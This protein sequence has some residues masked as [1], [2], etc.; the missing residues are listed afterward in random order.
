MKRIFTFIIFSSLVF[1]GSYEI[2]AQ[3]FS[4]TELAKES[5]EIAYEINKEMGFDKEI[6]ISI[7]RLI[8]SLQTNLEDLKKRHQEDTNSYDERKD[9]IEQNFEISAK[10]LLGEENYKDFLDLYNQLNK[11]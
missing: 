2:Q 3:N 10:D 4:N 11:E 5:K 9:E 7:F 8:Y 1:L 6:Q